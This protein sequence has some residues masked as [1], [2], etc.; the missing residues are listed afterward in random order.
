MRSRRPLDLL[1]CAIESVELDQDFDAGVGRFVLMWL[2]NPLVVLKRVV[3]HLRPGGVVAF[4]DNDFTFSIIASAPLPLFDTMNAWLKDAQVP[5]GPDY[6]MGLK[7]QHL[8]QR[9]LG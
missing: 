5:D 2:P 3:R 6:H 9:L 1:A 7:M 8:N 4:Q